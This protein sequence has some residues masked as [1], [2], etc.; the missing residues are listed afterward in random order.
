VFSYEKSSCM[1]HTRL[2][3][4]VGSS[5]GTVTRLL[6]RRSSNRGLLS[7]MLKKFL[8]YPKH[9]AYVIGKGKLST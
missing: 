5:V 6:D 3:E 8:A 4:N 9:S 1:L 7:D 2:I